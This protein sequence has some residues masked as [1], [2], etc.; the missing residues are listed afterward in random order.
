[1]S[2]LA[3]FFWRGKKPPPKPL[4]E[5][6]IRAI[7]REEFDAMVKESLTLDAPKHPVAM[8]RHFS[9]GPAR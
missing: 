1:M 5:A 4:T 6:R 2:K 7:V 9:G 8:F 3:D